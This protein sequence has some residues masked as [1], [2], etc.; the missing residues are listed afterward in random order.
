MKKIE[1]RLE[2]YF[3]P[4]TRI[5]FKR[6]KGL[7]V[8]RWNFFN[9]KKQKN[10]FRTQSTSNHAPHLEIIKEKA[11]KLRYTKITQSKIHHKQKQKKND[12]LRKYV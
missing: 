1:G 2:L 8:N 5:N 9:L 4:Y 7:K 6:I 3:I 12:Q 10:S 11:V